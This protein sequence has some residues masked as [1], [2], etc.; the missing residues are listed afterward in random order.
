MLTWSELFFYRNRAI[1]RAPVHS[2]TPVASHSPTSGQISARPSR[3]SSPVPLLS[4]S[5]SQPVLSSST[6]NIIT[7][8]ASGQNSEIIPATIFAT[9]SDPYAF[10]GSL[11]GPDKRLDN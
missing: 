8:Q 9:D 11:P 4:I 1:P 6:N 3:S 7:R 5:T 10:D 2:L